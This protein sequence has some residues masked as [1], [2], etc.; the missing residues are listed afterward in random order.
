MG[1]IQG[2]GQ[3]IENNSKMHFIGAYSNRR[4]IFIW[5]VVR[6][7]LKMFIELFLVF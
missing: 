1:R 5:G 3:D 6:R 7:R 2:V 4:V